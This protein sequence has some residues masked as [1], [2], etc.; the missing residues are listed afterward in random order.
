MGSLVCARV[1]ILSCVLLRKKLSNFYGIKDSFSKDL[2]Y[3]II[4][5]YLWTSWINSKH[6]LLKIH[7]NIMLSS[8]NI[9]RLCLLISHSLSFS[10]QDC[11]LLP[12]FNHALL[13]SSGQSSWLQIH[14]SGFD[15]R[16][17][18]IFWEVVGLEPGPLSLLRIIEELHEWKSSGSGLRNR[19]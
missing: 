11:I 16:R 5:R 1:V 4:D 17:Y 3:P 10:F 19:N 15:S 13:W 8:P 2:Q 9:Y 14:R 18:H 12:N 7:F 6:T